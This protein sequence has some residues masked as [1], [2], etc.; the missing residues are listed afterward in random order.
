MS[1]SV[2]A[3]FRLFLEDGSEVEIDVQKL[4]TKLI[5]KDSKLNFSPEPHNL[6]DWVEM[7][8]NKYM[9]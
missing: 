5:V 1:Q 3:G 2:F 6:N 7:G 4:N 9:F 8:I